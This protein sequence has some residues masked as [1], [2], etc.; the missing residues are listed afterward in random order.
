[1][2]SNHS[3][4]DVLSDLLSDAIGKRASD[5]HIEPQS[6][7]LRVRLR[8]DGLLTHHSA[9]PRSLLGPLISRIKVLS[10][11]DIGQQRLPQDG[12]L[13]LGHQGSQGAT[14]FRVSSCPTLHGE[15]IVLR[16]MTSIGGLPPLKQLGMN[17]RQLSHLEAAIAQPWG[18][19]LV[20][21]PTGSGKTVTLYSALRALNTDH[22]NISTIEDPIE[23][24]LPGIN[25]VACH[26]SIGLGFSQV[27]RAFL[28]QDPD[29][30]MVGE[31][32]DSTTAKMAVEAAQTGHLVFSTL[33]TNT[34]HATLLRLRHL[35]VPAH[36]LA[37]SLKLIVSQALMRKLHSCKVPDESYN[38]RRFAKAQ[39]I[40]RIWAPRGCSKCR[41]G[42]LGRIGVFETVPITETI[43]D[44]LAHWDQ[45][46]HRA[47]H[48]DGSNTTS[49]AQAAMGHV[50]S[51]CSSLEEYRRVIS[52]SSD[53]HLN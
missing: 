34:A 25:Q 51:G 12:R 22:R 49:L 50:S 29:V 41:S 47:W 36:D 53:L 33:H 40:D 45:K 26:S 9:L 3:A 6:D 18:L 1:M 44:H 27:L 38:G 7:C 16:H 48:L 24:V 20:T 37:D 19:V 30:L 15:K 21:G 46:S 10:G 32:R 11:L 35:Q 31:I 14:E 5:I 17:A 52:Q 28:R 39:M 42:Y 13:K 23:M 8:I 4:T 43:Q 2:P